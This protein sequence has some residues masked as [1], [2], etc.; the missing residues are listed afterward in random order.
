MGN[1]WFAAHFEHVPSVLASFLE[2]HLALRGARLLDLGCGDGIVDL[3]MALRWGPARM[4]GVDI[5]S[6]WRHLERIARK[7][8]RIDGWPG[9]LAFRTIS[10]GESLVPFGPFDAIFS[11]SAFEHFDRALVPSVLRD[12]REALRPGGL[13][14]VQVEPLYYS[15]YGSHLHRFGQAPWAHLSSSEAEVENLVNSYSGAIPPEDREINFEIR[16]FEEYKRFIFAEYLKLN[17]LTAQEL[18]DWVRAAGFEVLQER[19]NRVANTPPPH[20]LARH[21]LADLLT[22]EIMLLA[23]R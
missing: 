14:F 13:L 8:L 2:R 4:L 21:S 15:P 19:R 5:E 10:P 18:A 7:E 9:N 3:A 17:R 22:N 20:L 11:W 1:A 12:C 6:T 23:R 16:P